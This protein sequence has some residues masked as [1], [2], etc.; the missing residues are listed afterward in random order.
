MVSHQHANFLINT[1]KATAA[2]LEGLGEEV[3]RRVCEASGVVLDW[4]IERIGRPNPTTAAITGQG[5]DPSRAAPHPP[6]A[7][8]PPSAATVEAQ[9]SAVRARCSPRPG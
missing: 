8:G 4:E 6:A 2:D 3:R 1:G 7:P 9:S 5:K